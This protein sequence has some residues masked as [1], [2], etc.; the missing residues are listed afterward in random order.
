MGETVAHATRADFMA[1]RRVLERFGTSYALGTRFLPADIR[2]DVWALYA[3][4]R[5]PDEWV[6]NPKTPID[7]AAME[8]RLQDW[9]QTLR[10]SATGERV[11]DV[12]LRAFGDTVRRRAIP[13][14]LCEEFLNAMAM[15]LRRSRYADWDDLCIYMRG[16]AAVVG[17]M[18]CWIMD[19]TQER[20]LY[21][22]GQLGVAMQ[23]TNFL[24]DIGEDYE[25]GR[26]YIPQDMLMRHG[27]SDADIAARCVDARHKALMTELVA[28]A[29]SL[30]RAGNEGIRLLPTGCRRAIRVSSALYEAILR[31]IEQQ[32]YDVYYQRARTSRMEKLRLVA[33]YWSSL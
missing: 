20:S 26:I 14:C 31:K 16:S 19:S 17:E 23:L 4:V 3:F 11:D 15:D 33:R 7:P 24:R 22:A 21:A 5:S 28:R 30:Y 10:R 27:L 32:G 1:C 13:L 6:D 18:M 29:R 8:Q 9:M 25:R 2:P 12:V